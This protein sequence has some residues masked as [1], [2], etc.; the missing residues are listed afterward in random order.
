ML[1]TNLLLPNN[2][3]FLLL[4]FQGAPGQRGPPGSP[5]VDGNPGERGERGSSGPK[6]D[7]GAKVWRLYMV[8]TEILLSLMVAG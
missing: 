4:L 5:G 8:H 3:V 1:Y 7:R 6:G 2:S